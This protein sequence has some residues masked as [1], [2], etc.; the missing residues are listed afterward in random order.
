MTQKKKKAPTQITDAALLDKLNAL[1]TSDAD[2]GAASQV[3]DD[4]ALLDNLKGLG[5]TFPAPAPAFRTP[6]RNLPS[7]SGRRFAVLYSQSVEA[8]VG[9]PLEPIV[10]MSAFA[11]G[12]DCAFWCVPD[13]NGLGRCL[14]ASESYD[15][16]FM[17]NLNAILEE[18]TFGEI[19][20]LSLDRFFSFKGDDDIGHYCDLR[21]A[22][23]D[24]LRGNG[25]S[26]DLSPND[27]LLLDKLIAL[28]TSDADVDAAGEACR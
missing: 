2:A 6:D 8:S 16:E 27:A 22:Y 15:S 4:A 10:Q 17:T 28:N 14:V 3:V 5:V 23:R 1:N 11:V 20:A 9:T 13:E 21:W 7:L 25:V 12:L 26:I 24:L 19:A 18:L